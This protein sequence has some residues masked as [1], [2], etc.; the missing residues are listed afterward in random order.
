MKKEGRRRLLS[1]RRQGI[2]GF[3]MVGSSSFAFVLFLA[4]VTRLFAGFD[5]IV[6]DLEIDS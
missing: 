3:L 1:Y 4:W 6:L 5:R 2:R